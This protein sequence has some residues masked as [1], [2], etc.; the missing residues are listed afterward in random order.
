M[1]YGSCRHKVGSIDFVDCRSFSN[2][3]HY[4]PGLQDLAGT[5]GRITNL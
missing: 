2:F 5:P 4:L 3:A 1:D